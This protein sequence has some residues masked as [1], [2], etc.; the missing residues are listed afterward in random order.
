MSILDCEREVVLPLQ[1]V[2]DLVKNAVDDGED[3]LYIEGQ[4]EKFLQWRREHGEEWAKYYGLRVRAGLLALP[5]SEMQ[6]PPSWRCMR[7]CMAA[8][9]CSTGTPLTPHSTRLADMCTQ[10]RAPVSALSMLGCSPR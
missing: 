1:E 5:C 3:T 6:C 9:H 4:D 7:K 8:H 10:T 2:Y